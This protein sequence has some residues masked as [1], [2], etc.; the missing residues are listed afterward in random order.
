MT[1]L[2]QTE[3]KKLAMVSTQPSSYGSKWKASRWRHC[4]WNL[5]S[6]NFARIRRNPWKEIRT[7]EAYS[8][9]RN[10]SRNMRLW[11]TWKII[12][13][14]PFAANKQRNY[15]IIACVW[16]FQSIAKAY[17]QKAVDFFPSSSFISCCIAFT[18]NFVLQFSTWKGKKLTVF[19][20]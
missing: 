1:N 4:R 14:K 12:F 13:Q 3:I 15:E 7:I 19:S 17:E 5:L 2:Y 18:L 10:I 20:D 9:K 8:P 16:H 6:S 11:S